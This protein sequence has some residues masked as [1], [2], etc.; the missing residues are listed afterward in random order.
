MEDHSDQL[1]SYLALSAP[2][3]RRPAEGNEP[4]LRPEIGFTPKWYHHYLKINFDEQWHADPSYRKETILQMRGEL[5]RRFP[6]TKIGRIDQPDKPLDILTGTYGANSIAA[7]Y[8]IPIVYAK[9]NWPNS[10]HEYLSE[11]Q[12]TNLEPPNLDTNEHFQNLMDQVELI[13]DTEG[14]IEGFI[15]WQGVLN[16]AQRLRG[17]ELFMDMMINPDL[18]SHLFECVATTMI[19]AAKR[20]HK[21]QLKSGVSNNFFTM[22]NCLVNMV[23]SED[24]YRLL[25]PHDQRISEAFETVGIHNCSWNATPYFDSYSKIQNNKYID[26]G[27][28]SDLLRAKKLFPSERRSIMYTPMDVAN[29]RLEEIRAD[30][31]NIA[32]KFGPCDIVA[33]DIEVETPDQRV[34][35]FITLCEETSFKKQA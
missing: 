30:L 3:T 9:D 10:A 26:M 4:F 24:Y 7:I 32:D 16:N 12:I 28:D 33:A 21:R 35:D 5:H 19:D 18:A 8:G 1:I 27:Q 25:L 17:Q 29:K 14:R 15:N 34:L 31:E 22:S 6:N 20:L 11:E 2:A 13:A 23:S